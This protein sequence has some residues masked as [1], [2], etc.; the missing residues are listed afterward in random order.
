[1]QFNF[2]KSVTKSRGECRCGPRCS[3]G[4]GG[5]ALRDVRFGARCRSAGAGLALRATTAPGSV[6]AASSPH[7]APGQTLAKRTD[8][9]DAAADPGSLRELSDPQFITVWA[10]LRGRLATM[11]AGTAAHREI[12]RA[13]DAAQAEYRRRLD[14]GL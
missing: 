14:G 9:D 6:G 11:P 5:V 10:I 2:G 8:A 7:R 4:L 3:C 12:K 13:Y 1:M